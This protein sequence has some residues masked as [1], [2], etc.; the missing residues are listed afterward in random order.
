MATATYGSSLESAGA[1]SGDVGD[2]A[3]PRGDLG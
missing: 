2:A 3:S 1:A